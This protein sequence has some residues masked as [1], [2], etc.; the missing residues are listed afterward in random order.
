MGLPIIG[1]NNYCMDMTSKPN[2]NANYP[3][4]SS[5]QQYGTAM[6]LE[7]QQLSNANNFTQDNN[8]YYVQQNAATGSELYV[9]ASF[10]AN[11]EQYDSEL[12]E[13]LDHTHEMAQQEDN[14]CTTNFMGGSTN[15]KIRLFCSTCSQEFSSSADLNKHMQEHDSSVPSAESSQKLLSCPICQIS[16]KDKDALYH[17]TQRVHPG[18]REDPK[19]SKPEV[20][21]TPINA[22]QGK[23]NSKPKPKTVE[24]PPESCTHCPMTFETGLDLRKHLDHVHSGR[25]GRETHKCNLCG[26]EFQDKLSH[27]AHL[28]QHANEKRFKC[29]ICDAAVSSQASLTRHLKKHSVKSDDLPYKCEECGKGFLQRFGLTR[30][31]ASHQRLKQGPKCDNCGKGF[32]NVAAHSRHKCKMPNM[33]YKYPCEICGERMR[34]KSGWG[35]HMWRHTKDYKYIITETDSETSDEET[36]KKENAGSSTK[37][38]LSDPETVIRNGKENV[39]SV[40]SVVAVK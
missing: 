30:H 1:V 8:V 11:Q 27:K 39:M 24:T 12:Q 21:V 16:V 9:D 26:K 7:Q 25:E 40:S 28:A 18:K 6:N 20:E 5:Q 36:V 19:A 3:N 37:T 15:V 23:S 38:K 22:S 29:M 10:A 31:L 14:S 32:P 34:K 4:T 33:K 13:I 35:Y 17:H 2:N